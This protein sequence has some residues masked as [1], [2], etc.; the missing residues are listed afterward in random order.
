MIESSFG[1]GGNDAATAVQILIMTAGRA[2]RIEAAL[3]LPC[4][5]S[6]RTGQTAD[7]VVC[8]AHVHLLTVYCFGLAFHGEDSFQNLPV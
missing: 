6:I 5:L 8:S 4:E 3:P 1:S 7:Q 2:G